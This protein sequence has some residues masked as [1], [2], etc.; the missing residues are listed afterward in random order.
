MDKEAKEGY[1]SE[2]DLKIMSSATTSKSM[3]LL[4]KD[5]Y[6]ENKHFIELGKAV[7]KAF[8]EGYAIVFQDFD[9]VE[10]K[11]EVLD[12]IGNKTD[13]LKWAESEDK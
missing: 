12:F 6:E 13:L 8:N 1:L 3:I 11:M 10:D 5:K 9:Y 4:D 2:S 7:E